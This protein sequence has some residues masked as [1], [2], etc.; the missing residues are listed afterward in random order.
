[1]CH[2][3]LIS[4]KVKFNRLKRYRELES[5]NSELQAKISKLEAEAVT[6][7]I[8]LISRH[9]EN[10]IRESEL[11]EEIYELKDRNHLLQ[12]DLGVCKAEVVSVKKKLEDMIKRNQA[13]QEEIV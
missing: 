13:C 6:H 2:L 7:S 4:K 8:T 10:K 1:M 5:E 12:H 11:T 3:L 9:S